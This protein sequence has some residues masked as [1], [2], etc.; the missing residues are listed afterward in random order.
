MIL[1]D[2]SRINLPI[3]KLALIQRILLEDAQKL[4][5]MIVINI[6]GDEGVG[7]LL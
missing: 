4:C 6:L 1:L 5:Q 3:Q 7:S 2:E